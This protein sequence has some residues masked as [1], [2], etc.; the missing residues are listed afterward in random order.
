MRYTHRFSWS[1]RPRSP[2][3]G[4]AVII[5]LVALA[6]LTV[7]MAAI[8]WYGL[9]SRRQIERRENRLQCL[10]LAR[11][12]LERA[13]AHLLTGPAG[14]KKESVEFIPLSQVRIEVHDAKGPAGVFEVTCV[15]RFPTDDRHASERTLTRRYRRTVQGNRV[16]VEVVSQDAMPFPILWGL[17]NR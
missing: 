4:V 17:P 12:G 9:A 1:G 11:A 10:W 7:V 6:V 15:A 5:A 16:R 8:A 2:R 14:Y 3:R 13:A